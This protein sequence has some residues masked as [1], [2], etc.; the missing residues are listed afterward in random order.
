[1]NHRDIQTLLKSECPF[2]NVRECLS[3]LSNVIRRITKREAKVKR[4]PIIKTTP[5]YVPKS[6]A[7]EKRGQRKVISHAMYITAA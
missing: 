2:D 1:M 5:D 7:V 3:N 4:A 6:V